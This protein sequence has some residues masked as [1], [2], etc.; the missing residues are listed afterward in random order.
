MTGI[1]VPAMTWKPIRQSVVAPMKIQNSLEYVDISLS[2]DGIFFQRTTEITTAATRKNNRYKSNWP[3]SPRSV[4]E[5]TEPSPKIPLR[6]KKVA[7]KMKMKTLITKITEAFNA[8]SL[9]L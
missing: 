8:V 2:V 3:E 6:V 1:D 7:Y 5:C 9:F 4:K